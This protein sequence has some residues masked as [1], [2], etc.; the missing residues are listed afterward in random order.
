MNNSGFMPDAWQ[1]DALNTWH[2][3]LDDPR[4]AA[5]NLVGETGEVIR[6]AHKSEFK[7]GYHLNRDELVEELGDAWYYWRICTVM[8]RMTVAQMK[9]THVAGQLAF[10][11]RVDVISRSD[12]IFLPLAR[13]SVAASEAWHAAELH[14]NAVSTHWGIASP[15]HQL[16]QWLLYFLGFIKKGA[17]SLEEVHSVNVAKLAGGDNHGWKKQIAGTE[18][19][20]M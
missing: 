12:N 19:E 14:G 8:R 4:N 15:D 5:M 17:I 6:L 3:S 1:A 10:D 20:R 18:R 16:R 11:L 2:G 7:P 13:M 9:A